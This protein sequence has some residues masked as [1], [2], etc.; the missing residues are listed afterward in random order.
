METKPIYILGAGGF[1]REV[2]LLVRQSG[3]EVAGFYDD[4]KDVGTAVDGVP[5]VGNVADLHAVTTSLALAIAIADPA[6][7]KKLA[8]SLV[9]PNISYPVLIH[10][11]ANIGDQERNRFG[12]GTII[13]AGTIMTTGIT[14]GKFVFINAGSTIGHDVVLGDFCSIM[15]RTSLSG[16]VLAGEGILFGT[17]STVLPN[18]S[19]GSWSRIGAGAVVTREVPAN[20]TVVGIPATQ[21]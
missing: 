11:S 6:V 14:V 18:L 9:N 8:L 20:A 17:S 10:P 19:L 5:V 13:A 3:G 2:A 15:P 1:G 21:R 4:G 16:F 12:R 7:R